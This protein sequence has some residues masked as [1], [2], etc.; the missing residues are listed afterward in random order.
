MEVRRVRSLIRRKSLVLAVD[1]GDGIVI[2][3]DGRDVM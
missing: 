3:V 2:R 1:A